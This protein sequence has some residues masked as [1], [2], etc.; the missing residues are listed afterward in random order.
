[1]VRLQGRFQNQLRATRS[2][3]K[4]SVRCDQDQR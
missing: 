2:G 3:A 4:P 1:M